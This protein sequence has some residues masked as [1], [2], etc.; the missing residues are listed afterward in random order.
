MR[1]VKKGYEAQ[2]IENITVNSSLWKT[3]NVQLVPIPEVDVFGDII[4][5]GNLLDATIIIENGDYIPADTVIV[6]DGDYDFTNYEGEHQVTIFAE[7]Y[8]PF[9]QLV[10][11]TAGTY[12]MNIDLSE[13]DLSCVNFTN[14]NLSGANLNGANLSNANL[15]GADLEGANLKGTNLTGANLSEADLSEA[16]L[17][18]ANLSNAD[19]T[20][21]NLENALVDEA[22]LSNTKGYIK[23]GGM[24]MMEKTQ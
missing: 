7:G 3:E 4:S 5:G 6:D 10:D 19:L 2:R 20:D 17:Y 24:M 21:A 18:M 8:I 12:E 15:Q 16:D 14:A 9:T 22:D 23:P 1:V 13:A 11:F